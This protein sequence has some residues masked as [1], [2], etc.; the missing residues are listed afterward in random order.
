MVHDKA[1]I[2]YKSISFLKYFLF[3]I[4]FVFMDRFAAN[5]K[6]FSTKTYSDWIDI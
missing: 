2:G 5:L 6:T 4:E 3:Q 1:A